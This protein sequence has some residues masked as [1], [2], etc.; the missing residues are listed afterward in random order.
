MFDRI[1]KGCYSEAD[2]KSVIRQLLEA[3]KFLHSRNIAHRD[4]KP[5]NI[6]LVSKRNNTQIKLTGFL[7]FPFDFII[8]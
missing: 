5:E 6:L 3:L 8:F 1:T 2:A 4:L 7:M